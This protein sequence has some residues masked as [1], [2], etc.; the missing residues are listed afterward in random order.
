MNVY[1][2]VDV[3]EKAY[4]VNI[5]ATTSYTDAWMFMLKIK[6]VKQMFFCIKMN[7]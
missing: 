7:P 2:A 5:S 6:Y 3:H 1:Y 4:A